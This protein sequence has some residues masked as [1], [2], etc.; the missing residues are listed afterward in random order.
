MLEFRKVVN[1]FNDVKILLK[2]NNYMCIHLLTNKAPTERVQNV[3]CNN[4]N[5]INYIPYIAIN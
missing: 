3:H 2:L 1:N 4:Y 5:C